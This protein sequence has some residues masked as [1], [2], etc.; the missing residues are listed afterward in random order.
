MKQPISDDMREQK[1][2]SGVPEV[3]RALPEDD[4]AHLL[5]VCYVFFCSVIFYLSLINSELQ[6]I[7]SKY[8]VSSQVPLRT[9]RHYLGHTTKKQVRTFL[10]L[11]GYYRQFRLDE[12]LDT[13][14]CI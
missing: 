10:G 2:G 12:L 5:R 8:F 11:V 7:W 3:E 4:R 1:T 13:I 9:R 6:I 14:Y